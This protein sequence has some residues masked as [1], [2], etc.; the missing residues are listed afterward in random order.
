MSVVYVIKNNEKID[1]TSLDDIKPRKQDVIGYECFQCK[2]IIE[3]QYRHKQKFHEEKILCNRC[4]LKNDNPFSSEEVKEKIKKTKEK[5]YSNSNFTNRK[6]AKE[7][8]FIRYGVEHALKNSDFVKKAKTT[9]I[10]KYGVCSPLKNHEIY[11]KM[12]ETKEKKYHDKFYNNRA[13]F[14]K[15]MVERYGG[16]NVLNSDLKLQS[17]RK[18]AI[19]AISR[20]SKYVLPL[21]NIEDWINKE[22]KYTKLA[23]KCVKCGNEFNDY[24]ANGRIPRCYSCYPKLAGTS[25]YEINMSQFLI[26][27]GLKIKTNDRTIIPPKELDIF[28]PDH[29]LA[30]ELNGLYW[31]SELQG[32]DKYYHLNKTL[33]CEKIGIQLIHIFEDEWIDKQ[34]I[35]KSIIKGKLGFSNKI[36]GRKCK[37]EMIDNAYNFYDENH[38]QGGM[39]SFINIGLFYNEELV[40]VLSFSKP[41][42]N[43]QY[44]W[45]ITRFANKLNTSVIGGFAKMLKYFKE[46]YSGNVITYSDKRLFNGSIYLQNGFTQLKSSGP[47]YY[48]TDYRNRYNR[49]GFQKHKL[50]DKLDIYDPNLT[51]WENM[52]LNGW[53]RIWDCGNSVFV[54]HI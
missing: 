22:Q 41:R 5:R 42:Y 20:I 37:V 31:H 12:L 47:S 39:Y 6:K 26:N 19:S 50:K 3:Q 27:L 2:E 38:I 54:L 34:D 51:E 13:K 48:Y 17:Y 16:T 32:K 23:W 11:S 43:K 14:H 40:S 46:K 52:Q 21:F 33:E 28:I 8:M 10:D 30:I 45:E 9:N 1:T 15:T 24:F 44:D 7:T 49:V 36:Y 25:Q 35:V 4:R 53:D 29:K 18:K